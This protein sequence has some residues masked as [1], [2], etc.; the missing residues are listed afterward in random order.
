[1]ERD[2]GGIRCGEVLARLGDIVD[3]ELSETDRT[4]I[5]AHVM[6]CAECARFGERYQEVVR[7]LREADVPASVA[8]AL[9]D[10]IRRISA[11]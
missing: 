8:A 5:T 10:R 6:G 3:G 2:I 1:M 9:D 7:A 4:R 11:R